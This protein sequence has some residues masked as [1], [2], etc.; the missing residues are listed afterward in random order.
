VSLRL[1]W[2]LSSAKVEQIIESPK[3]LKA[4]INEAV[5]LLN[6]WQR[7]HFKAK[8]QKLRLYAWELRAHIPKG[9]AL[10]RCAVLI[11]RHSAAQVPPDD[12]NLIAKPILDCLV[13]PSKRNPYGVG[14]IK[15]DSP[16][17][18]QGVAV[19]SA[20]CGAKKDKTE[21]YILPL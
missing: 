20:R 13:E 16:K 3:T 19:L 6:V 2:F 8:A 18:L 10:Q 9:D 17:Y 21:V 14:V 7:L 1:H 4:T 15:D 11:V 12:D 5:P